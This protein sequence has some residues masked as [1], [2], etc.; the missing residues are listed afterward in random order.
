MR[1][2]KVIIGNNYMERWVVIPN[3]KYFNIYL[4]HFLHDDDDRA[5]HD[6]PWWSVSFLLRGVLREIMRE[7]SR[8]IRRWLPVWR[9]PTHTHRLELVSKEALTLF[10][11]GPWVREWGFHCPKGWRHWTKFVDTTDTGKIGRGCD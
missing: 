2:E 9:R 4:H 3:N 11:T 8:V 6:H 10:I 1:F 5:L 7:Q